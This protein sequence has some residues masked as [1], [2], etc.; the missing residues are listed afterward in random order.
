VPL[1]DEQISAQNMYRL[2]IVTNQNQTVHIVSP[3]IL[4][5]KS[6]ESEKLEIKA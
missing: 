2:L 3:V 5:M 4:T 6:S 1:D